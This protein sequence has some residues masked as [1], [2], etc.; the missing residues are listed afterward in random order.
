MG[1]NV[2]INTRIIVMIVAIVALGAAIAYQY[3]P[4]S[5]GPERKSVTRSAGASQ[6]AAAPADM[7]STETTE[8]ADD[9]P[10]QPPP[11]NTPPS[12][13]SVIPF[14]DSPPRRLDIPDRTS[15]LKP[16]QRTTE[17]DP[18]QVAGY[19]GEIFVRLDLDHDD[20]LVRLEIPEFCRE[21]MMARDTNN[22]GKIDV[23]EFVAAIPYLPQ[24]PVSRSTTPASALVNPPEAG[25]E[26]PIYQS[27]PAKGSE[28]VPL[29]FLQLDSNKDNMIAVYEWP[30]TEDRNK[31][32]ALDENDDG[33][34]TLEEARKAEKQGDSTRRGAA[35]LDRDRVAAP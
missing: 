33:F 27:R 6:V 23:Q 25:Q 7:A 5:K 1:R 2:R 11:G 3:L 18:R 12:V 35:A 4:V 16:E 21:Q 28:D 32:R 15:Q 8:K 13:A 10:S 30:R 24:P 31:F 19:F 22:D 34:I 17:P 29:W 9:V 14:P 20:R 26:I